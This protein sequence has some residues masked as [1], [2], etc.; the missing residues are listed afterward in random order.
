M[1]PKEL[2][3]EDE[4]PMLARLPGIASCHGGLLLEPQRPGVRARAAKA[5]WLVSKAG[6]AEA[7]R[8]PGGGACT[9]R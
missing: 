1:V 8:L 9:L 5:G 6:D 2:W 4:V 3:R 7:E